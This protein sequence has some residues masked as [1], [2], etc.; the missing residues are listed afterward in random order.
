MILALS[1]AV[2]L[3][4]L[5]LLL[6]AII[7][8]RV[9]FKSNSKPLFLAGLRPP[10][11]F[12][13]KFCDL[14][15]QLYQLLPRLGDGGSLLSSVQEVLENNYVHLKLAL[16]S[17]GVGQAI[18]VC[19]KDLMLRD[20]LLRSCST[21]I[22][23]EIFASDLG[24][25]SR[26]LVWQKDCERLDLQDVIF[27]RLEVSFDLNLKIGI[28]IGVR[29]S[30]YACV[31]QIR[32]ICSYAVLLLEVGA[33]KLN[34][35]DVSAPAQVNSL[36]SQLCHDLRSPLNNI[37][38]VLGLLVEPLTAEEREGLIQ[39][40]LLSCSSMKCLVDNLVDFALGVSARPDCLSEFELSELLIEVVHEFLLL[41]KLKRLELTFENSVVES[42]VRADR[43]QLKRVLTNLLS[44][45]VKYTEL[46][47]VRV[48]LDRRPDSTLQVLI[49]DTGSGIKVCSTENHNQDSFG[50]GLSVVKE[51]LQSNGSQLEIKTAAGIG[52]TVGFKLKSLSSSCTSATELSFSQ[53]SFD[54]STH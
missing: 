36:S 4:V 43:L 19:S 41:A 47:S 28:W 30:G 16:I 42:L 49:I 13:I 34:A 12:L 48:C 29:R 54:C 22:G 17:E 33:Q 38:A 44:N 23:R 8:R 51:L 31:E 20:F 35:L 45:A 15:R 39:I 24:L 46:G 5:G 11:K 1:E 50:L 21:S 2:L 53:A 32:E 25:K 7:A 9:F 37:K 18:D 52:T 26:D 3:L 27:R 10:E 6:L 14:E 40:G